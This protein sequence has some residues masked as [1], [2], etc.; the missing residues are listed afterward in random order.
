MLVL[1]VLESEIWIVLELV[2]LNPDFDPFF[3]GDRKPSSVAWASSAFFFRR[4]DD[5]GLLLLFVGNGLSIRR[6]SSLMK[7]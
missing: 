1:R 5:F 3:P 6:S 7:V 4:G 2:M